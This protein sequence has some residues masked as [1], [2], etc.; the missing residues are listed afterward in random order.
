MAGLKAG[1]LTESL[2]QL[3]SAPFRS[4]PIVCPALINDKVEGSNNF[5]HRNLAGCISL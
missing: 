3:L 1:R 4:C 5:I 2:F